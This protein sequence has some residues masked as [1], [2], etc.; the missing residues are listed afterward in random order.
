MDTSE[1]LDG[2]AALVQ[3]RFYGKHRGEVADNADPTGRGRLLVTVPAVL[4]DEQVWARP[5]VP[6]AGKD[7]GFFAMPD[8]GAGV[9]IEFE[10]GDISYP[11]WSGCFWADGEIPDADAKPSIKFLRTSRLLVRIDDDEG[12]I[13][14]AVDSGATLKLSVTELTLK[15]Q[16]VQAESGTKKTA[17]T[18]MSFDVH[19]GAFTV[20]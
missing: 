2:V 9:W 13:E 7:V 12:T 17:L 14:I 15:A 18:A 16:T 5:C 6:Y 3:S 8:K 10:G 11:I 4:G 19:D 1:L 20:V